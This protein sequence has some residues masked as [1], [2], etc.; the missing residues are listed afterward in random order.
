MKRPTSRRDFLE[1][2]AP[3]PSWNVVSS[4]L[5]RPLVALAEPACGVIPAS[6]E[7]LAWVTAGQ[8]RF[9]AAPE[10]NWNRAPVPPAAD[11]IRP[12]PITY[13]R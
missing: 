8:K 6:P 4:E 5:V 11:H 9:A 13:T 12:S 2:S 3:G 7:K 1:L 10:I